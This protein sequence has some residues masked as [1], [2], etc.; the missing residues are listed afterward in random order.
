MVGGSG[1]VF[2][3]AAACTS[4]GDVANKISGRSESKKAPGIISFQ[5]RWCPL[6]EHLVAQPWYVFTV[7]Y[8]TDRN[9]WKYRSAWRLKSISA[10]HEMRPKYGRW[11]ALVSTHHPIV[12][13]I[14]EERAAAYVFGPLW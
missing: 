8:G 5:E 6:L 13:I 12:S 4:V 11:D 2:Q 3:R 7:L 10:C 1:D 14:H 9:D